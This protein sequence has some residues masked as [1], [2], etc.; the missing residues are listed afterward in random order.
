MSNSIIL[1]ARW[2]EI[3]YKLL[4]VTFSNPSKILDFWNKKILIID[5]LQNKLL[6]KLLS[7]K[8][9][10]LCQLIWMKKMN[11][12]FIAKE[13]LKRY[14]VCVN[15]FYWMVKSFKKKTFRMLSM[16]HFNILLTLVRQSLLFLRWNFLR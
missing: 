13:H 5:F 16:L 4:W 11:F 2:L 7:L 12:L 15:M 3:L 6:W 9:S 1:N 10:I 14:G 8:I